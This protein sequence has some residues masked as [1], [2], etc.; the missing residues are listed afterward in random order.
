MR[1]PYFDNVK[2]LLITLVVVGHM[3]LAP[4]MDRSEVANALYI[5]IYFFHMPLF[6]FI[7]G[8]F[9]KK[10][11]RENYYQKV[12]AGVFIPY[13]IFQTVYIMYDYFLLGTDELNVSYFSPYYAL[14]FLLS[15]TAWKIML[16]IVV[17]LKYPLIISI[18]L[19]I[20]IGYLNDI[21]GYLSLSRT[22]VFFPF[23]LAG[24]YCKKEY[25]DKL[26][27]KPV[28]II[29]I[30]VLLASMVIIYVYGQDINKELL[31][32]SADFQYLDYVGLEGFKNRTVVLLITTIIGGAVLSVTPRHKIPLI[33]DL[34]SRTIYAYLLHAFLVKYLSYTKFYN[35]I[36][37]NVEIVVWMVVCIIFTMLLSSKPVKYVFRYIVE[38]KVKWLFKK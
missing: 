25:L 35:V 32:G 12:I 31:M 17:K 11:E 14:W 27:Q 22:F 8:Y 26:F 36:N 4:V 3:A 9:S 2:F 20:V 37:T 38:T 34:G 24:F 10:I 19:A 23:F 5:F 7:A 29:S 21:G 6:I 28:R 16:P 15:L 30:V 1:E 18:V 13:L 33:S